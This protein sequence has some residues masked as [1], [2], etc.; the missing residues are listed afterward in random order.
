MINLEPRPPRRQTL[1][2]H[3]SLT[4][5]DEILAII[6]V[7]WYK[8]GRADLVNEVVLM[9]DDEEGLAAFAH[10]VGTSMAQGANV[11]VRSAHP[12]EALGIYP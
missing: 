1:D 8:D 5:P 7:S 9:E 4:L 2:Y 6:R 3:I 11:S 12:P 10:V